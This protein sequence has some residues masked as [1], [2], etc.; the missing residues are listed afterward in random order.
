MNER[1]LEQEPG[2]LSLWPGTERFEDGS[3]IERSCYSNLA[4]GSVVFETRLYR[5]DNSLASCG[6]S[7]I[8]QWGNS[9]T[10]A[11]FRRSDG[12]L[13]FENNLGV[14]PKTGAS[15][16]DFKT[17]YGNEVLERHDKNYVDA[18]GRLVLEVVAVHPD[19]SFSRTFKSLTDPQT[20]KRIRQ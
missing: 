18:L 6:R 10:S 13:E 3:R 19:G 1:R 2:Q 8:D 4:T 17:Y 16:G 9:A 14:D 12:S 5:S 20:G 11:E 15:I 7:F